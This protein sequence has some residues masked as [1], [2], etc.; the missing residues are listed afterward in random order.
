MTYSVL[1]VPLNP[2]RPT[3]RLLFRLHMKYIDDFIHHRWRLATM[4]P[5]GEWSIMMFCSFYQSLYGL[6]SWLIY[7]LARGPKSPLSGPA[8]IEEL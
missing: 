3:N 1:K 5:E 8:E 7:R 2:N 6:M 4:A